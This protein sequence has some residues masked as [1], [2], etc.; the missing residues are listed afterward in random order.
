ML[1]AL[2]NRHSATITVG[3]RVFDLL[4]TPLKHGAKKVGFMVEWADAKA[5]LLNVDYVAQIAAISRSQAIIDFSVD[6]KIMSVNQN[7]FNMVG[8]SPAE[9]IGQHHC[10]FVDKAYANS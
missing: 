8:Y 1:A 4:V 2:K 9:I 6:G 3:T 5:R 10:M 7:F